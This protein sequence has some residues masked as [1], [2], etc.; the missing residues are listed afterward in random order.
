MQSFFEWFLSSIHEVDKPW[1]IFGK[2]PTFGKRVEF[3][4]TP[5]NTLS[6]NHAVREQPV[7]VA[8]M[9]DLD[10]IERCADI[11]ESNAEVVVMPWYPHVQNRPGIETLEQIADR[12]PVLNKLR[13]QARLLWYN[14]ASSKRVNENSPVVPVKFFSAEAAINL[15]AIAGVKTI[16]SLGIDGGAN[17]SSEFKDLNDVTL[18][19]NG[20]TSFD[21][22][23]EQIAKTIMETHVDYAP[24]DIDS[25]VKVFVATTEAQMLS[26]RVLEFSIRKHASMS[27]EVFPLHR[28][29]VSIPMPKDPKNHPRTPFSFQRF[30]IP[31]LCGYRGRAIYLDSDMQ[32]FSDIRELWTMPFEDADLLAVREPSTTGRKPQFSVMLLNCEELRWDIH[33]IVDD[34][35]AGKLSY[36][37]LMYQMNVARNVRA[38]IEPRWN[39]LERF[40]KGG[41]SLL[42]YTDMNTQPWVSR[43]NPIGYLWFRDLFDAIDAGFISNDEVDE[44]I[45]KGYVRPSIRYQI[46]HRIDDPLLL[47]AKAK[48]LD[49]GF[50]APYQGIPRHSGSPWT[51]PLQFLRAATRYLYHKTP[52]PRLHRR[53]SDRFFNK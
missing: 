42:H 11:L 47:P 43:Q 50:V 52:M 15:L 6:L 30:I 35:D 20:R 34:L 3:D 38:D 25:P 49:A 17:Y 37:Q 28:A 51:S 29:D 5:F 19:A 13:D 10:V 22:Q 39:C 40:D 41:T 14:L 8:H 45:A 46:D 27:I 21:R 44:H 1:L 53:I 48:N 24:L 4:L 32:V 2:G 12:I 33:K 7:R 16:R 31:A 36:E 26:V 9:I 23:F 18:L